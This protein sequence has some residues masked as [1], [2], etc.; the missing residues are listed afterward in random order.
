MRESACCRCYSIFC[1]RLLHVCSFLL[2]WAMRRP[3]TVGTSSKYSSHAFFFTPNIPIRRTQGYV[4]T[5]MK[6]NRQEELQ[7]RRQFFKKA[8]KNALP[9]LGAIAL[10]NIPMFANATEASGDCQHGCTTG[11]TGCLSSCS[12]S[13][14]SCSDGC[15]SG[16]HRTC[17]TGCNGKTNAWK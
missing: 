5:I 16:C 10:A 7:S 6:Q 11:C 2:R 14:T 3:L 17:Y 9:I 8:A 4:I 13:C 15:A 1:V 12:R